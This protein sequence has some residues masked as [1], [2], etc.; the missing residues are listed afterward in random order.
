MKLT[1]YNAISIDGFIAT[2]NGDTSW[3]NAIDWEVFEKLSYETKHLICGRTTYEEVLKNNDFDTNLIE[4]Y[5]LTTQPKENNEFKSPE[6]ILKN[7]KSK[8][9][10]NALLIGGGITNASFLKENL[11][12][13]VILSIHP[14]ILGD[15][16]RL[17]EGEETKLDLEKISVTELGEGL[18]QVR[19]R[20]IK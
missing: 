1:L 11:I 17:F 7:L 2:K 19:Y 16:V 3:V 8:S 9:V 13:E 6:D 10:D 18:V 20:V 14:I 15:G 4:L 5:C 12:D